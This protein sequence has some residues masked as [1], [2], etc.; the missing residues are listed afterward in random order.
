MVKHPTRTLFVEGGGNKNSSLQT[1]CRR[2]FT[3]LLEAV[4]FKGRLPRI[5]SCGG[6]HQAYDRFCTA[7]QHLQEHDV[8]V[9]LVDSEA[10]VTESSPWVHVKQRAGDGWDK[11][12]GTSDDQLHFMVQ[13]M[14]AWFLADRDVMREFYGSGYRE[15]ALPPATAQIEDVSKTDLFSK[16]KAATRDTTAKGTYGKGKHSFKLLASLDPALVRK[17]SPWAERF[18]ST[19]DTLLEGAEA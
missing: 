15:N 4:G 1:E 19:L 12:D 11:P 3:L 13:C 9:L 6:R 8:A 17:A 7:V 16:L 14:E 2:A 10:A 5:I 18:F